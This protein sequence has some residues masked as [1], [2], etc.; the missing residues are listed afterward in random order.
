MQE[1][2]SSKPPTKGE[3]RLI[4]YYV[5]YGQWVVLFLS[6][7]SIYLVS[8]INHETRLNGYIL[9]AIARTSGATI[10]IFVD[11]WAFVV[12]NLIQTCIACNGYYKN[13]QA[14]EE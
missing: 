1:N 3:K 12:A 6:I 11:L 10:L 8:S 9:T 13:K 14:G 5:H 7:M 4:D 2:N